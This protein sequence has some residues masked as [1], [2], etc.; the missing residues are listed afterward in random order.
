M[1]AVVPVICEW[2]KGLVAPIVIHFLQDLL[3]I[4]LLPLLA[5]R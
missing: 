5:V 3:S 2:R 4:L 1:G